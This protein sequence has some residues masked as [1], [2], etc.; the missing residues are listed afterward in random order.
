MRGND[1][2]KN[3]VH[4]EYFAPRTQLLCDVHCCFSANGVAMKIE[5]ERNA[6]LVVGS[7]AHELS[8]LVGRIAS[9]QVSFRFCIV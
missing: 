3:S 2:A 7:D 6:G 8:P 1:S 4:E 9:R 5:Y